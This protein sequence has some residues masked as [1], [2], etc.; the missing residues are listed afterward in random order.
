MWPYIIGGVLTVTIIGVTALWL[1]KRKQRNRSRLIS[2]VALLREPQNLEAIYIAT[3][4]RKAWNAD[5][6]DGTTEGDDGS[7]IGSEIAY[8]L[9]FGDRI[10]LVNNFSMP[11]LKNPAEAAESINDLR[12][13]GIVADHQAWL[14]C[15]ALG[16]EPNPSEKQLGEWYRLLGRLLAE[17]IDDNCLAVYLPD[18]DQLYAYNSETL[19]LLRAD[20]PFEAVHAE[21]STVP[22][23]EVPD[24][25]PE[26]LKAVAEAKQRWSEFIAAFEAQAGT[27]FAVKAPI[28]RDEQTE[29]IWIEVTAIE[30]GVIFGKLANE[31]MSLA[32]LELGSRVRTTEDAL[33]DWGYMNSADE[34]VGGFTVKAVVEASKKLQ[35]ERRRKKKSD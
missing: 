28:T 25:A 21:G 35:K 4:A 19:D 17:L 23:I 22:V 32:G 6:G 30:N 20:D 11:Y 14:S 27:N 29:F 10:I 5:L 18:T 16:L 1:W 8:F 2:F 3:A 26:M 13:R 24:D 9:Q 33:N 31:P 7:V 15:D 34:F 12:L